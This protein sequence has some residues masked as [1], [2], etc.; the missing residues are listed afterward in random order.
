M[1]GFINCPLC[2]NGETI[3][4]E[5]R[6]APYNEI[7]RTRKC[8]NGH[9]FRTF[10]LVEQENLTDVEESGDSSSAEHQKESEG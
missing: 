4:I 3:V 5:T 2:G 1:A 7:R 8:K 9:R 10:E 6:R